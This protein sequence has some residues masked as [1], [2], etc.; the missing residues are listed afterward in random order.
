E[1]PTSTQL[2]SFNESSF[3]GNALCGPPL[4]E[5]CNKKRAPPDAESTRDLSSDGQNWGLII[6]IVLGFTIG[7]WAVIA[8][9]IAS[10]IWRSVYFYFLYKAWYKIRVVCCNHCHG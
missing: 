9:L 6:S 2:Q 8:P 10:K 3:M 1:I 5:Q 7:F 4:A